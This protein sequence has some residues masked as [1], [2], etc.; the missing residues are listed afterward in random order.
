MSEVDI[1]RRDKSVGVTLSTSTSSATTVRLED[2][3]GAIVSLGTLHT[4]SSTIHVYGSAEEAGPYR[5][6]YDSVGSPANITLQ[7]STSVG[8]MYALPDA[9]FALPYGKLI[10]GDEYS[11]G[12]SGT[13]MFKS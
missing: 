11:T 6:L 4:S 13:I 3:A 12:V 2:A 1:V 5:R 10:S 9:I 7:P 8:T